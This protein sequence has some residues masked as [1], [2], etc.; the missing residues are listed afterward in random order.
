MLSLGLRGEAAN[1]ANSRVGDPP[2][3]GGCMYRWVRLM[4]GSLDVD[5]IERYVAWMEISFIE[6]MIAEVKESG[7]DLLKAASLL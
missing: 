1:I 7:R 5:V 4:G 3:G 2:E 6:V